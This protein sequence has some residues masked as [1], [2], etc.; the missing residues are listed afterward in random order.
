MDIFSQSQS[1]S[2]VLGSIVRLIAELWHPPAPFFERRNTAPAKSFCKVNKFKCHRKPSHICHT[3]TQLF[4]GWPDGFSY[5]H[6]SIHC[7]PR[8]R[9]PVSSAPHVSDATALG[10]YDF[11]TTKPCTQRLVLRCSM[12]KQGKGLDFSIFILHLKVWL[13]DIFWLVRHPSQTTTMVWL[14]RFVCCHLR[15]FLWSFDKG[16]PRRWSSVSNGVTAQWCPSS[17]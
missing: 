14:V 15:R 17:P 5:I 7:C 3:K 11:T 13:F 1:V 2:F 8:D 12:K 9:S 6:H 4:S 10:A 16:S